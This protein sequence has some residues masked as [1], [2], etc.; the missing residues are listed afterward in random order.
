MRRPGSFAGPEQAIEFIPPDFEKPIEFANLFPDANAPLE[1]D[2]GCGDGLF[3][4]SRA[5]ENAARNF[6]GVERLIGR[7]RTSCRRIN[8]LGLQNARIIRVEIAHAV[9][10]LLPPES[11]EAFYLLFPDPWPKRRHQT[12]RVFNDELLAA[13]AAALKP[14][15]TFYVATDQPEYAAEMKRVVNSSKFL[16]EIEATDA[17]PLTT[18][19][20]R[21]TDAGLEIHR[22]ALRKISG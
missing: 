19:G 15:G 8:R 12:R 5:A 11:V 16:Q 1:V 17:L 14:S 3:L 2:L 22:F 10:V 18:F 20:Q 9:K 4:S 7:V 6:L 21:F 13:I